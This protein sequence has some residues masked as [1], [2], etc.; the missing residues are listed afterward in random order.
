MTESES[1][2][3]VC[4]RCGALIEAASGRGRPR[5]WC[6]QRCRRGAY[7][8]RRAAQNGAIAVRIEVV[9]K[10]VKKVLYRERD[11]AVAAS[12][13]SPQDAIQALLNSPHA[14]AILLDS[15]AAKAV[16][17]DLRSSEHA[18]TI[19]A[20]ESLLLAF[21]LSGLIKG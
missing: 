6:S 10:T 20:A 14:C 15:L 5:L 8:E 21:R 7:E 12:S 4:P 13:P 9:E 1:D 18:P 16:K 3:P 19:E 17:G 11:R 2:Q